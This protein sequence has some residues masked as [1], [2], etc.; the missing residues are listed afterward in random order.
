ME[1]EKKLK[2]TNIENDL[3][4]IKTQLKKSQQVKFQINDVKY[5]K[6]CNSLE[7][8]HSVKILCK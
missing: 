6:I 8:I 3:Q 4:K 1:V 7:T 5:I 2:K